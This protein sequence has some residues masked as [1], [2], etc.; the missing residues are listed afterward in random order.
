MRH[1]SEN[2]D[3]LTTEAT[4]LLLSVSEKRRQ[5]QA[6]TIPPTQHGVPVT[7]VTNV[8]AADATVDHP[9]SYQIWLHSVVVL[10]AS[11]LF[12]LAPR[13]AERPG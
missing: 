11:R 9:G 7:T 4:D 10:T 12:L 1:S 2:T 6:Q 8:A 5:G 13:L 3:E